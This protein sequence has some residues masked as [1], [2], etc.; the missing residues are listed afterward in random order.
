MFLV[1]H[2]GPGTRYPLNTLYDNIKADPG[3]AL[4]KYTNTKVDLGTR[5]PP[6]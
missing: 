1:Y 2:N 3:R 5:P 6:K 4:S